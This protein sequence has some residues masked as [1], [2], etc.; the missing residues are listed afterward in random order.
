MATQPNRF[1]ADRLASQEARLSERTRE[2]PESGKLPPF[3]LSNPPRPAKPAPQQDFANVT[4]FVEVRDFDSHGR[5]SLPIFGHN[6]SRRATRL[7]RPDL[8][9]DETG[10]ECPPPQTVPEPIAACDRWPSRGTPS[11]PERGFRRL[12]SFHLSIKINQEHPNGAR[13]APRRA[14]ARRRVYADPKGWFHRTVRV[15]DGSLLHPCA[16]RARRLPDHVVL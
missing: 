4:A 9:S 13:S 8:F 12:S 16:R 3:R 6:L 15:G 10:F 14:E 5:E 11:P 2:S 1:L 7:L